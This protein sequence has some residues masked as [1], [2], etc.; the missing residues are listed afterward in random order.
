[1]KLFVDDLRDAPDDSWEVARSYSEA[2][3]F[4][5]GTVDVLSLDHDLGCYDKTGYDIC[6]WMVEYLG[7]PDW[8]NLIVIH[9]ANPV[10]R[11]NMVQLLNRYAPDT[12]QI[13]VNY[14]N[15]GIEDMADS[16]E[17]FVRIKGGKHDE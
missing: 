15:E 8:P 14:N 11:D 9:T 2:M 17:K 5:N 10:G 6:K 3:E 12:T 1:M 4:M 13:Q 16:M 7:F